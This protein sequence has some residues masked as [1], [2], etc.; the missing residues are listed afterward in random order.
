MK[1]SY[2]SAGAVVLF[3]AAAS[4]SVDAFAPSLFQAPKT[5]PSKTEGVEIELPD[6]DE[7]FDRIKKV[8]P[9]ARQVIED[10]GTG[11]RGFEHVNDSSDMKWKSIERRAKNTVHQIDKVDNYMKLGP[12]LLR[13]RASL[14]GPCIGK[15][16]ADFIMT[17]DERE[18]WDDQI[19]SVDELYP[20]DVAETSHLIGEGKFG[21]CSRLGVGYCKTKAAFGISPREQLTICGVQ[22]FADGSVVIWG[23][24]MEEDHNHLLP[25]GKRH[26]RAKS[27]IFCTTLTPTGDDTFDAEYILQMETGGLPAFI[28]T[29]VMIDT[30]KS[31]FRHAEAFYA[32]GEGSELE[33]YLSENTKAAEQQER[34][35]VSEEKEAEQDHLLVLQAESAAQEATPEVVAEAKKELFRL[36]T[37]AMEVIG[38][39]EEPNVVAK[40]AP[41]SHTLVVP[42]HE[43]HDLMTDDEHDRLV[44]THAMVMIHDDKPKSMMR[45]AVTKAASKAAAA[46]SLLRTVRD[47]FAEKVV[48]RDAD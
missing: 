27:H 31:L 23:T 47:S 6:F 1:V 45:R 25:E 41:T 3:A 44:K 43:H 14:K 33:L 39:E 42:E 30:V 4:V 22:D 28:T 9:L 18:R 24:E 21:D 8:S 26:T 20:I 48:I 36:D 13:F 10:D 35:A 38:A 12:P 16:F 15:P 46:K 19:A 40:A 17:L 29:P 2:L 7:L 37:P 5:A 11:K 34:L 32:G